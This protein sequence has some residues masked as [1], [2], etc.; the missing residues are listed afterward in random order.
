MAA[1]AFRRT[2][3]S[4]GSPSKRPGASLALPSPGFHAGPRGEQLR[5]AAGHQRAPERKRRRLPVLTP[6]C[7]G[8][9][10]SRRRGTPSILDRTS[11]T[12]G[13]AN[14]CGQYQ[15]PTAHP[16][17]MTYLFAGPDG[18]EVQ[19]GSGGVAQISKRPM[20]T[21][22]GRMSLSALPVSGAM[23]PH[24]AAVRSRSPGPARA[25]G[26][27]ARGGTPGV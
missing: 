23:Q 3:P 17:Q 21:Y 7:G 14:G 16:C 26:G 25:A 1:T 18:A 6:A 2:Q 27:G 9:S 8:A 19:R 22:A 13:P 11:A 12:P 4:E 20:P 24:P 15:T 10:R 5:T